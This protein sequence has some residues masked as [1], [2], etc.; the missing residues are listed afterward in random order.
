MKA[1]KYTI[2]KTSR[3]YK[4]YC[5]S[6]EALLEEGRS[7]KDILEEIELLTLLIGKWD[8]EHS[9]LSEA[10]PVGLLQMLMQEH[11]MRAKDLAE[12]LGVSKGLVSDILHY[13]KGLSKEIIRMLSSHFKVSQEAFNR[14]YILKNSLNSN[15][16]S[17]K[18]TGASK[19]KELA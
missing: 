11:H 1:M 8:D 12:L 3:Q 19:R 6:L 5:D 10:D 16:R 4:L 9:S 13:K 18:G 17:T 2:I 7:A 14:D 15:L